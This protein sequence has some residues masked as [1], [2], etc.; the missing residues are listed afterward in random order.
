MTHPLYSLR[1]LTDTTQIRT[2]NVNGQLYTIV[3]CV[4]LNEGVI[5]GENSP[6]PELALASEFGANP[7]A[8]DGC[9]LV[10]DH[11]RDPQG[12]PTSANS[13]QVLQQSCFGQ[14][15]NTKVEDGKLKTELW[16]NEGRVQE[17][18]GQVLQQVNKMKSGEMVEVSTG[19]FALRESQ[20]GH[21]NG[22]PY[23]G[24][25][26][27]VQPDHL[28]ILPQGTL[29]A[30]SN[31]G[32]CGAPRINCGPTPLA[33]GPAGGTSA[34]PLP[35]ETPAGLFT[36]FLKTL[37]IRPDAT[38]QAQ[39]QGAVMNKDQMISAI[40]A[41]TQTLFTEGDRAVLS[42]MSED[43]L[44]KIAPHVFG[45][46]RPQAAAA[47]AVP[48]VLPPITATPQLQGGTGQPIPQQPVI[49]SAPQ[50]GGLPIPQPAGKHSSR[51]SRRNN[52]TSYACRR[53]GVLRWYRRS[54]TST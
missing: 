37:G 26:K 21:F 20:V 54:R 15:F 13:P 45:D 35:D 44:K 18:N 3:P 28:A 5:Q 50:G 31:E 34:P 17:L 14:I 33:N 4:A 42:G 7:S 30:C 47:A 19:L 46:L 40:I 16:I 23:N 27:D 52:I 53:T 48:T 43:V 25:W 11:P 41:N 2:E 49:T 29:G 38:P 24:V 9:P 36:R 32:G 6:H 51:N 10:L 1:A 22:Q 39:S 8:W 12:N